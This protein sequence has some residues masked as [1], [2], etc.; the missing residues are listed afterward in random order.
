M[1]WIKTV[2][3]LK[4]QIVLFYCYLIGL[5]L[6]FPSKLNTFASY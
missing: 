4:I 1:G 2:L 5:L 6:Y 3:I